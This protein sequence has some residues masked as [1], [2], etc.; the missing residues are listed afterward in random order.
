M[1]SNQEAKPVVL[2]HGLN[3]TS[4]SLEKLGRALDDKGFEVHNISYPSTRFPI[5]KLAKDLRQGELAPLADRD[6]LCFVTHSMGGIIL[7]WIESYMPMPG[8]FRSVMLAPPNQGSEVADAMMNLRLARWLNGPALEQLGTMSNSLP[9]E[10]EDINFHCGVLAGSRSSNPFF[11]RFFDEANDGKV[12]VESTKDPGVADWRVLDV[13]HS[14]M[15][16]N[17]AVIDHTLHF[18]EHGWFEKVH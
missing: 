14:T 10:L 16:K 18:L 8:L 4:R 2:L 7:R 11:R 13:F 9:L 15:M 12:A 5:E 1:S 17:R 6:D 3:R